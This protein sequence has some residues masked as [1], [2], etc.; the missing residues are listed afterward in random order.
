MRW[1]RLGSKRM[2]GTGSQRERHTAERGKQAAVLLIAVGLLGAPACAEQIAGAPGAAPPV[3]PE[4]DEAEQSESAPLARTR[5]VSL[6]PLGPATDPCIDFATY[7]CGPSR[8]RLVRDNDVLA[9]RKAALLRFLDEL[10]AGRHQD[11]SAATA[12]VRDFHRR[13]LDG[14]ARQAGYKELRAELDTRS[15]PRRLCLISLAYWRCYSTV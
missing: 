14:A 6:A 10:M 5:E 15:R 2:T 7:A 1:I 11:G 3:A 13:C 8:R 9:W 12:L 4:S